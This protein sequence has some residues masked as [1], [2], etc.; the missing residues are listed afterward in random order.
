[1]IKK[2]AADR[3]QL[4]K[5]QLFWHFSV[6]PLLLVP[7]IVILI[8]FVSMYLDDTYKTVPTKAELL[9]SAMIFIGLALISFFAQR[10]RLRFKVFE[11]Q[12]NDGQF[13]NALKMTC[14]NLKWRILIKRK[15]YVRAGRYW[16][17]SLSWGELITIKRKKGKILINSICDPDA[18]PSVISYGWNRHNVKTFMSNLKKQSETVSDIL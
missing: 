9:W 10:A 13:E 16:N 1:M 5:R 17:W 3:I 11:I 2:K 14:E 12:Y 18:I 15:S 8:D 6:V 4:T 7:P